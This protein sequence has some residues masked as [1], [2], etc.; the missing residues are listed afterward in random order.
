M[1]ADT[2]GVAMA[3]EPA[4]EQLPSFRTCVGFEAGE[5][6]LIGDLL[7]L[8]L[9]KRTQGKDFNFKIKDQLVSLGNIVALAGDFYGNWKTLG[10]AEQISDKWPQ[11]KDASIKRFKANAADLATD[12]P[13]YLKKVLKIMAEE[14]KI[15][16]DAQQKGKDPAQTYASI[17]EKFNRKY[18]IATRYYAN[19]AYLMIALCNWDHFGQH[20]IYAYTAGH[21]AA[22]EK[23]R[24]AGR[25]ADIDGLRYAYFLEGF[26]LHFLTDLFSSGHLRPPRKI[27]HHSW[28]G[29]SDEGDGRGEN[30]LLPSPWPADECCKEFHDEDCANGLFVTNSAGDSWAMYGDGQLFGEKSTAN[31]SKAVQAA[32]AGMD[33]IGDAFKQPN[34]PNS[35]FA[36]LKLVADLSR[37]EYPTEYVPLFQ[38]NPQTDALSIRANLEQ[39]ADTSMTKVE[40]GFFSFRR[41]LNAIKASGIH[42][43]RLPLTRDFPSSTP[44]IQ[45]QK[46]NRGLHFANK[47][48]PV[49][50]M[51]YKLDPPRNTTSWN[52][53][54]RSKV[55]TALSYYSWTASEYLSG[56]VILSS[57]RRDDD[58][59][60]ARFAAYKLD[61]LGSGVAIKELWN[62]GVENDWPRL[63]ADRLVVGQ[64]A[65]GS[66]KVALFRYGNGNDDKPEFYVFNSGFNEPP[67]K[68]QVRFP[69]NINFASAIIIGNIEGTTQILA[70]ATLPQ[71]LQ[72]VNWRFYEWDNDYNQY[73]IQDTS[74]ELDA[75]KWEIILTGRLLKESD[76]TQLVRIIYGPTFEPGRLRIDI[77]TV[78]NGRNITRL[79]SKSY[80]T[81][82][83]GSPPN[84]QYLKWLLLDANGNG[85]LDIVAVINTPNFTLTTVIFPNNGDYQFGEPVVTTICIPDSSFNPTFFQSILIRPAVYTY[86]DTNTPV[87]T[88]ILQLFSN[89]QVLGARLLAPTVPGSLKYELKGQTPAIAGQIS[90][91]SGSQDPSDWQGFFAMQY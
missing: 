1:S 68:R 65:K 69:T 80:S 40:R 36:A 91:G 54:S 15:I 74:E 46:T 35:D 59:A 30:D 76:T 5:H 62:I 16:H 66:N 18:A 61:F 84:E 71:A 42:Q 88:G 72:T 21:T 57:Q 39:R 26:A 70:V 58:R 86:P 8:N 24:E 33:E 79:F 7:Y 81:Q 28:T 23:A 12:K 14:R 64:F 43:N 75:P 13:G 50:S 4:A 31:L 6:T 20:A 48:G 73:S 60:K 17:A 77:L 56:E 53:I 67:L 29:N 11:D 9:D 83:W 52:M 82:S 25:T 10:D 45:L 22:F 38:Y 3:A 37:L 49:I 55:D 19:S 90:V 34:R 47:Y 89:Y 63:G 78:A 27:L 85:N 51:D 2:T 32:Q 44:V 41:T 87:K